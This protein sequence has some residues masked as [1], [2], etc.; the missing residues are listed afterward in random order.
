M[1]EKK[2][3]EIR[4]RGFEGE[5]EQRDLAS[6][7]YK[8]TTKNT[9]FLIKETFTNS[10]EF[11]VIGQRD[12]FDHDISN[13]EKT[14]RYYIVNNED[15]YNPR[16][17]STAPCGPI[18][19]NR[20]GRTGI[21]SP[22]YTAFRVNGVNTL[23]LEWYFK[24][25]YWHHYM[26]FNGN[27]GARSDR[28]SI[29]DDMFF[30][31]PIPVPS[32]SEQEK[33]GDFFSMLNSMI[34][35]QCRKLEKLQTFKQ[36]MLEK[37][38]PNEGSLIPEIRFRGFQGDWKNSIL[39]Y[40]AEIRKGEQRNKKDLLEYGKYYVLNGGITPSGYTNA[41]NTESETISISEGGNSCGFVNYNR[42]RFWSGGHNYTLLNAQLDTAF[43][44]QF[45][46]SK[47]KSI[48]ALRVG[49]GL[50]NIQKDSVSSIDV[51]YPAREE[52][53]RIGSFFSML[54]RFVDCQQRKLVKLQT[55]KQSLLQ[56][57]FV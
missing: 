41:Y 51:C 44:Y 39:E 2:T 24:S 55:L 14:D 45:L 9:G 19:C 48:M 26:R 25:Q 32:I 49:S 23:F 13:V 53:K 8:V 50:P 20:L 12:F 37:M 28:F 7:A 52:Q 54:D 3:P 15:L 1:S 11:G 6:F 33:I 29:S 34:K 10:A 57:M 21:I 16:V 46:K 40:V 36:A 43:L 5:W 47:E 30:K 4:F 27:S 35:K 18:N 38:F 22:L 17:S 31:M 56:K 42:E